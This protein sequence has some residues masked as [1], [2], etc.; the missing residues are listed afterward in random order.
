[1]DNNLLSLEYI[2][3]T[4]IVIALSFTGCIYGI[5]YSISYD[6]FSMTAVAFFPILSMFIAFVLA[7]TILFLSLKKYKNEKKVNH[8]ANFYYVTCTFILSGIMIFLIDV[9]VYALIDKTLSLKYAETLQMISR[10]YAVTSKNIDYVKKIPFILQSGIMIFTGL[11][12]GS[13]SSL[14]ILS[15][16]KSLKKQPDLQS[17]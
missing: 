5:A 2:F 9:F 6:N 4:S 8:I 12:A 11:L 14:F 10:Q 13:F 1:M 7:A 3:I 17:I 16:Y 15:Q